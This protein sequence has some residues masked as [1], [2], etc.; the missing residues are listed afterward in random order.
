MQNVSNFLFLFLKYKAQIVSDTNC[1][2][3]A[4]LPIGIA[5]WSIM[6]QALGWPNTNIRWV[7]LIALVVNPSGNQRFSLISQIERLGCLWTSSIWKF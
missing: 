2:E 5:M 6:A 4:N 3:T 7:D 1:P